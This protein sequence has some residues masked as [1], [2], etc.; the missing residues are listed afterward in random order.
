MHKS[1]LS[2]LILVILLFI[3]GISLTACSKEEELVDEMPIVDVDDD[4]EVVVTLPESYPSDLVPIY[5]DSHLFSVVELNQSFTV[6]FY[7]KDEASLVI[8][9]YKNVFR[10]ATNKMETNQDNSYTIYG[11]LDGYTFTFDCGE[12]D[13]LEGYQTLVLLS[14]VMNQK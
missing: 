14:V 13:D 1:I 4:E 7:V 3:L 6:M 5:P 8:D 2:K 10:N 11:E 9:F 12:D